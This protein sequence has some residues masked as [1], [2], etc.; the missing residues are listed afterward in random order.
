MEL[1][2]KRESTGTKEEASVGSVMTP[3]TTY[4]L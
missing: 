2:V 1:L 4:E 3:T